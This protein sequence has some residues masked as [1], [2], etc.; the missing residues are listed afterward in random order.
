[1]SGRIHEPAALLVGKEPPVSTGHEAVWAPE[2]IWT[3]W[4][5]DIPDP[6]ANTTPFVQHAA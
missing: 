4:R 5:Q 1:V 2:Q 6:T 3:R